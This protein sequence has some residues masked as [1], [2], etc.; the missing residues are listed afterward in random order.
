M[1]T[2]PYT[3]MNISSVAFILS[4]KSFMGNV[5]G[6]VCGLAVSKLCYEDVKLQSRG[7][8]R[9]CAHILAGWKATIP[10]TTLQPGYLPRSLLAPQ[11]YK[12]MA[13]VRSCCV[14]L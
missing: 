3:L 1:L 5:P 11:V 9:T 2:E 6:S 7:C 10:S 13:C 4:S 14:L 8:L 12:P